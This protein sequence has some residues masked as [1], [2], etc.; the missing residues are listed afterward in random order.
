MTTTDLDLDLDP[1][2]DPGLEPSP[3]HPRRLAATACELD[4]AVRRVVR[5]LPPQGRPRELATALRGAS[6]LLR[7]LLAC[8]DAHRSPVRL[9]RSLVALWRLGRHADDAERHGWIDLETAVELL[10]LGSRLEIPLVTRLRAGGWEVPE[11]E[12]P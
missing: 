10:E 2:L 3:S 4:A 8:P 9:A 1:G 6:A 11:P 7:V 12:R 5:T